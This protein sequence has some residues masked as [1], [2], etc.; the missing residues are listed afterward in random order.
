MNSIIILSL[1]S[2]IIS[3]G[4]A[5][6]LLPIIIQFAASKNLMDQPDHRK[7]H[8]VSVSALGGIAIFFGTWIPTMIVCLYFCDV[9]I[10]WIFVAALILFVVSL[11]DDLFNLSA[12]KRLLF[13]MI[14]GSGLYHAGFEL[15]IHLLINVPADFSIINY[16]STLFFILL[17]INAY[18][19][20]DG[21]DGLAGG[22]GIIATT[23]FGIYFALSGQVFFA[24][25]AF[26]LIG[27]LISFLRFNFNGAEIFMGDNGSTMIGLLLAIFSIQLINTSSFENLWSSAFAL[28]VLL[29]PIMD[30]FKVAFARIL[31]GRSPFSADRTHI[32]HQLLG[33][34]LSVTQSCYLLYAFNILVVLSVLF[35]GQFNPIIAFSLLP[36]LVLGYYT[37]IKIAQVKLR[38]SVW[39]FKVLE[40]KRT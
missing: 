37:T 21:I 3:S 16:L 32:H 2:L 1:L 29:I 34:G 35:I 8:A 33:L 7:T 24:V 38:G 23:I 25:L 19:F 10:L 14:L 22:L 13:Q 28:S 40:S 6:L 4:I 39:M 12:K 11:G 27:A 20:I 15:P 9:S 18:N 31:N 5:Y 17:L 36:F 30:L 26:G